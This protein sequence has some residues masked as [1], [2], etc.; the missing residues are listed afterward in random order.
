MIITSIGLIVGLAFL[1]YGAEWL[2]SGAIRIAENVGISRTVV[3]LTLVAFGTSAP[4]LFVNVVAASRGHIDF[5][6]A[7]VSGSNLANIGIGFGFCALIATTIIRR[8][9]F[10]VDAMYCAGAPMIVF[11]FFVLDPNG[12]LPLWSI[13]VLVTLLT[14]YLLTIRS[15]A[16]DEYGTEEVSGS[17]LNGILVFMSGSLALYGGGEVVFWAALRMA[18]SL[19]V[20]ESLVAYLLIAAGTSIPDIT[21]SIVAVRKGE[22][23]IAVGNLLGSNIFNVLLVLSAT[24][25]IARQ[26]LVP[27]KILVL[28][29]AAVCVI[30][31]M[32]VLFMLFRQRL[33]RAAGGVL[34]VLYLAYTFYRITY[35]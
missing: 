28:D 27:S 11:G 35:S 6:L 33:T 18:R 15:R 8:A 23:T 14:L 16:S 4:E 25:G 19:G 12:H 1:Y 3:G 2:V 22:N 13:V 9:E 32:L 31:I 34:L 5:A 7:N 21:A 10:F 20:S 30:S 17:L 24:L 26:P 29:Y